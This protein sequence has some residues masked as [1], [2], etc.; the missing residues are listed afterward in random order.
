MSTFKLS[1]LL[2]ENFNISIFGPLDPN[3]L[4]NIF[5]VQGYYSGSI[6]NVFYTI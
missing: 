1:E 3:N 6:K 5:L 4:P 2:S